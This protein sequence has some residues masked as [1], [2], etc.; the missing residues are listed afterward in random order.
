VT[1]AVAE[2]HPLRGP[3]AEGSAT[4]RV[5][6]RREQRVDERGEQITQQVRARLRQLPNPRPP[7]RTTYPM[8]QGSG[9]CLTQGLQ[10]LDSNAPSVGLMV[11]EALPA[12]PSFAMM[13]LISPESSF[14]RAQ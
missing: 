5:S 13:L 10:P 6:L 7:H 9:Y 11:T 4:H 12:V 3:L 1:V 8:L 2:V 14:S